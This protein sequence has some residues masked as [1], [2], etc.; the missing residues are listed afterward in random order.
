MKQAL[1]FSLVCALALVTVSCASNK[2][3]VK[4]TISVDIPRAPLAPSKE[5][6]NKSQ[7]VV[8]LPFER[9]DSVP[10][11][12][13]DY[14]YANLEQTLLKSGVKVIE[15]SVANK[16]ADELRAAILV[17]KEAPPSLQVASVAVLVDIAGASVASSFNKESRWEDKEGKVHITPSSC[18]YSGNAKVHL[19]LYTLP[20]MLNIGTYDST[21]RASR[22]RESSNRDCPISN[23][24]TYD[25][26]ANAVSQALNDGDYELLNKLATNHY[27][28]ERRQ[29]PDEN[30]E[31]IF[32][33]S[34]SDEKGARPGKK[35]DFYRRVEKTNQLTGENYIE[36]VLQASG[37]VTDQATE[38]G[39]YVLVKGEEEIESLMLGDVVKLSHEDC[40]GTLVLGKCIPNPF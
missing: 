30:D 19:R 10:S 15:R 17:G 11:Q 6:I 27:V 33:T 38:N 26:K 37:I 1:K 31:A 21:G 12:I 29:S 14:G 39:S 24:M 5:D 7:S 4:E 23:K 3:N 32:F 36:E 28:L 9:S 40:R 13:A 22:R 18:D 35:V 20:G 2:A 25:L 16:L 8:L 34:L